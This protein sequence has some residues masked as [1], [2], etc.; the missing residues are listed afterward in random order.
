M[1]K[2]ISIIFNKS[3]KQIQKN[4]FSTNKLRNQ[5]SKLILYENTQNVREKI[6]FSIIFSNITKW[7]A[8]LQKQVKQYAENWDIT[9][10]GNIQLEKFITAIKKEPTGT[11]PK[12]KILFFFDKFY[13]NCPNFEKNDEFIKNMFLEFIEFFFKDV[14][15]NQSRI[16]EL[17][18]LTKSFIIKTVVSDVVSFSKNNIHISE[19]AKK[20][21]EYDQSEIVDNVLSFLKIAEQNNVTLTSPKLQNITT[22]VLYKKEMKCFESF[23]YDVY[24]KQKSSGN[25]TYLFPIFKD[26]NVENAKNFYLF[27]INSNLSNTSKQIRM[28]TVQD[29]LALLF[30]ETEAFSYSYE[31]KDIEQ[32]KNKLPQNIQEDFVFSVSV[33]QDVFIN[34]IKQGAFSYEN[35]KQESQDALNCYFIKGLIIYNNP[36]YKDVDMLLREKVAKW[37]MS[38]LYFAR[39]FEQEIRSEQMKES[40]KKDPEASYRY[41]VDV[42]ADRF[43]EGE[44]TIINIVT[45]G[46]YKNKWDLFAVFKNYFKVFLPYDNTLFFALFILTSDLSDE[47]KKVILRAPQEEINKIFS[48]KILDEKSK[49]EITNKLISLGVS[50]VPNNTEIGKK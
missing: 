49:Q 28:E 35:E 46:N 29:C 48:L 17:Y 8:N 19:D 1:K 34:I 15:G 33:A 27:F 20:I 13:K 4:N 39:N 36:K 10:V 25:K 37:P 7:F 42:L 47:D 41:A 22:D 32:L 5:I 44:E 31:R 12:E 43:L 18:N 16:G 24:K 30:H 2:R 38:A 3:H 14:G 21:A 40:V 45:S 23:F 11:S 9:D 6:F 26:K 50:V